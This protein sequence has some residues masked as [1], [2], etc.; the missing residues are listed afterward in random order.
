MISITASIWW[1]QF[2]LFLSKF[3]LEE[4]KNEINV[5]VI[6]NLYVCTEIIMI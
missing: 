4:T 3:H 2:L 1:V 6:Y 5:I